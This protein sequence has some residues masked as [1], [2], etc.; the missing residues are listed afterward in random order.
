MERPY[1]SGTLFER[2]D[3]FGIKPVRF[4]TCTGVLGQKRAAA[5]DIVVIVARGLLVHKVHM[6]DGEQRVA[7]RRCES[8]VF[9]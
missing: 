6:G 7:Q 5:G 9:T 1:S 3:D 4:K 8:S 2:G